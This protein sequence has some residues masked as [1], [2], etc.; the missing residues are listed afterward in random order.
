MWCTLITELLEINV[1]RE[2]TYISL[3]YFKYNTQ[4]HRQ[5]SPL[6]WN[7]FKSSLFTMKREQKPLFS[8]RTGLNLQSNWGEKKKSFIYYRNVWNKSVY[9]KKNFAVFF[10]KF[11]KHN[12]KG[13]LYCYDAEG[14]LKVTWEKYHSVMRK[15]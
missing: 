12:Y 8:Q 9:K 14:K 7:T 6:L 3:Q 2:T 11:W 1:M 13:Y 4:T 15:Y 10:T 5:E